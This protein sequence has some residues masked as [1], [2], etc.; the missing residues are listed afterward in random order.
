[1]VNDDEEVLDENK[2]IFDWCMDG[3]LNKVNSLLQNGNDINRKD[4][5]GWL[6]TF[7]QIRHPE[8][9]TKGDLRIIPCF[10]DSDRS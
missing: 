10:H 7:T 9:G 3:N 5:L 8:E 2:T 6:P 4:H 1:M